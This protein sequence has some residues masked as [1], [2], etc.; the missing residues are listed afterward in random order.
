[1]PR[2]ARSRSN[3]GIYHIVLRGI[4]K[5]EIFHDSHDYLQFLKIIKTVHADS[6]FQIISF[7]LM[8]NHVHLSLLEETADISLVMKRIGVSYAVY[9]NRKYARIG[10]LFQDRFRSE[11]VEDERYLLTVTRYI[12]RN[13]VKAGIVERAEDYEWSS[14]RTYAFRH[15]IAGLRI[16][17][18]IVMSLFGSNAN[19][20]L[21]QYR[22]F[23]AD[24]DEYDRSLE[25]DEESRL[26]NEELLLRIQCLLGGLSINELQ[27]LSKGERD[28]K[29]RLIKELGGCT[30]R[31]IAE[32]TGIS[33]S[34]LQRAM[35]R[36]HKL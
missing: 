25:F 23:M 36:K 30:L 12:H 26:S 22:T 11:R 10:H 18:D 28:S 17:T 7:C 20:A 19:E 5:Q 35:A 3:S 1:M 14:A 2:A 21:K 4:N 9:Y 34:V 32:V 29:L 27:M 13:P 31:Q 24:N 33:K 8:N 15:S 6:G 16:N